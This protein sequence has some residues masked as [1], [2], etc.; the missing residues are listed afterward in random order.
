V[1]DDPQALSPM[2]YKQSRWNCLGCNGGR[3]RGTV[4]ESLTG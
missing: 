1:A 4:G 3:P 2:I